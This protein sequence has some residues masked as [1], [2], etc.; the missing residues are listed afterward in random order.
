MANKTKINHH[1][2]RGYDIRGVAGVDLNYEIVK[3]IA[4]GYAYFLSKRRIKEAVIGRD[5][6]LSG[7]EYKNAF[8]EGLT[9]SGINV[10]DIGVCL[11]QMVYFAQYQ[12]KANGAVMI[13]AS[14]NPKDYNGF[15]LCL[16]YSYTLGSDEIQDL[17][18]IIEKEKFIDSP[19][20]GNIVEID[21]FGDVYFSDIMKRI[22]LSGFKKILEVQ[23]NEVKYR[24]EPIQAEK[25][26][27]VVVDASNGTTGI[28]APKFLRQAGVEVIEQHTRVDGEFPNGTPDPTESHILNRLSKRVLKEKADLGVAYDGDGDRLGVVDE[29][30]NIIWADVLVAIFADDVLDYLPGGKIV[31][32]VLCS[33]LVDDVI[34]LKGIPIMHKTGHSFI[35]E[36]VALEN[37]VFGG[38]LSGHFFF[39]DNFYGHDDAIFATFRLLEYLERKGVKLSEVVESFPKYFSSPEIKLGVSDDEK[40]DL[41]DNQLKAEF[42]QIY[43]NEKFT[44]I[45]GVRVDFKDAMFVVRYSQNG[46]YITIK[47]EAKTQSEYDKI[48]KQ[49]KEKLLEYKEIDWKE[50]VNLEA[51]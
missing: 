25:K 7:E 42:K 35:K 14:H 19:E 51:F 39:V 2:F 30:G 11:T 3:T 10:I 15:K 40:V 13:T 5:V 34:S 47:F 45:D 41:V 46:P 4:K 22:N 50:G 8:A 48:K 1:I 9:E 23:S 20:K 12:F 28:F 27:K 6:R 49:L 43:P 21:N 31:Y 29:K 24:I 18:K 36:K 33:K 26:F 17:R 37:A 16:G 32:N 44:T 38:E